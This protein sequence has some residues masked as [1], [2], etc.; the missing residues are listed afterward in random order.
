MDSRVL[1]PE[2]NAVR[3]MADCLLASHGT[4]E[5]M[6]VGINWV[7]RFVKIHPNL[8][9]KYSR[10]FDYQRAMCQDPN[11]LISWFDLVHNTMLTYGVESSDVYNVDETGFSMGLNAARKV[12]SGSEIRGKRQLIQNGNREWVTAIECINSTGLFLQPFILFKG[13]QICESWYAELEED[14]RLG[15]S[16]NGWTSNDIAIRWLE[17]GFI[18]QTEST[19]KGTHRLLILDGHGS[20]LTPE[21][22]KIC[23]E[24]KIIALYM[25]PH[26][27]HLLQ[28]LD[29][30][31]FGTLQK[32]Y[33]QLAGERTGFDVLAGGSVRINKDDFV[34]LYK[35]ARVEAF[36]ARNIRSSFETAGLIPLNPQWVLPKINIEVINEVSPESHLTP[37][38]SS[39]PADDLSTPSKHS[40]LMGFAS[41]H[42]KLLENCPRDQAGQLKA[43]FDKLLNYALSQGHSFAI[44]AK[45]FS[46]VLATHERQNKKSKR[47]KKRITDASDLSM[48]EF[49]ERKS[50][51]LE[52][53]NPFLENSVDLEGKFSQPH[54]NRKTTCGICGTIGHRRQ[55]GPNK[56]Q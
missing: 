48:E 25:P 45:Q 17:K 53:V 49:N 11:V 35:L 8:D 36:T 41:S 31:C 30:C 29:L 10:P 13:K 6:K 42:Y 18:P 50:S 56:A 43:S 24:N 19:T 20:H 47:S 4:K 52:T 23:N 9:T 32:K 46:D 5:N 33:H 55:T 14:R 1:A 16:A 38:R 15:V 34:G 28:P 51:S 40:C 7:S 27:S 2:V 39:S 26:T 21:F 54:K 37:R 22:D 12:V 3:K 44:M